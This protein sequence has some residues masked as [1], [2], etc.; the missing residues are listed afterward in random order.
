MSTLTVNASKDS[1]VY[2]VV[3]WSISRNYG[4][5]QFALQFCNRQ[6]KSLPLRYLTCDLI[7]EEI[8]TVVNGERNTR[9]ARD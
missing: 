3:Q 6:A 4:T 5:M 7:L 1:W 8:C 2:F 9:G